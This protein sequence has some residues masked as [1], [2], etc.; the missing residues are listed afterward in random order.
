[1]VTWPRDIFIHQGKRWERLPEQP[2]QRFTMGVDLGQ[3]ADY[4]AVC[5]LHHTRTPL[6]E[7]QVNENACEI[8]QKV[9]ERFDICHL[10][11]LPLGMP[12]PEQVA[13]IQGLL[14]RP[15]LRSEEVALC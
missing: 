15:P 2:F 8:R 7:W 6:D 9:E 12:Y 10:Q 11:R 13:R 5:V 1:M 4:T 14:T 3:S